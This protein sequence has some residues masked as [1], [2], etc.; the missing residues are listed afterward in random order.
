MVIEA[1]LAGYAVAALVGLAFS[2]PPVTGAVAGGVVVAAAAAVSFGSGA[3]GAVLAAVGWA[4]PT[5]WFAQAY[6]SGLALFGQAHHDVRVASLVCLL[7]AAAALTGFNCAGWNVHE[8]VAL[9]FLLLAASFVTLVSDHLATLYLSLEL[10]SLAAYTLV[11]YY[12]SRVVA[13]ESALKYL[14]VGS[15]VS[16]FML[17]GLFMVYSGSGTLNLGELRFDLGYGAGW[18]MAAVVF[19]VGAAPFHFWA[20]SVYAS[21]EWPTLVALSSF[22]KLNIWVLLFCVLTPITPFGWWSALAAG[23]LSLMA[24]G[25]GGLYQTSFGGVL[26]YSAVLNSGYMLL[27]S[28][29]IGGLTASIGTVSFSLFLYILVY[30][31]VAAGVGALLATAVGNRAHSLG[32]AS[33]LTSLGVYYLLL[34]LGGLPVYPGFASKFYLLWSAAPA[35]LFVGFLIVTGSVL[36]VSF[37][38][39][40]STFFVLD[41]IV[42]AP[43]GLFDPKRAAVAA[44]A[45]YFGV[46]LGGFVVG[47]FV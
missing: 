42:A 6:T 45:A 23:A 24:G 20:P 8:Y 30:S 15:A 1:G 2:R 35:G 14:L 36:A 11:S 5:E 17:V 40:L 33:L 47:L 3:F 38:L 29:T 12:R 25:V 16:G 43:V 22:A 19:K 26:G 27:V 28:A 10:Q 41:N 4:D 31:L 46:V 9:L 13:A 37:Y 39:E 7:L 18:L 21:V 34:N 32:V 44:F